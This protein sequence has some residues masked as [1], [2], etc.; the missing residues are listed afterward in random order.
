MTLVR[1]MRDRDEARM[2]PVVLPAGTTWLA[3][4]GSADRPR[5]D[6]PDVRTIGDLA[7]Q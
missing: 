3:A 1:R 5:E 7:L 2:E 4:A 6:A